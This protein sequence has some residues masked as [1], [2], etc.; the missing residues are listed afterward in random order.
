MQGDRFSRAELC[1][2]ENTEQQSSPTAV[3]ISFRKH[4]R[5]DST[6]YWKLKYK[7]AM[8]TYQRISEISISL[9]EIPN[10]FPVTKVTP[11]VNMENVRVTQVHGSMERKKILEK[12]LS[13]KE[14]I[15][16]KEQAKKERKYK[17]QQQID[18]FFKCKEECTCG[19]N[20]CAA[21]K[22]QECPCCHNVLK[23]TCSKASSLDETGSKP[24]MIKPSCDIGPTKSLQ[25]E[26]DKGDIGNDDAD[27]NMS[28]TDDD[29][30]VDDD[31]S[32][33]NNVTDYELTSVNW[34]RDSS[35]DQYDDLKQGDCVKV[36]KGNYLW[37]F[38]LVAGDGYE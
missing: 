19:K 34:E 27:G 9:E 33:A 2:N 24:I 25:F 15:A 16:K 1:F 32:D 20:I 23:S 12:V 13:I 7:S 28:D 26:S 30:S 17:Q 14:D 4:V 36:I 5:Y 31:L 29:V 11:K 37:Y 18:S 22:L 10:L 35:D 21:T 38:A 6:T 3:A 8:K